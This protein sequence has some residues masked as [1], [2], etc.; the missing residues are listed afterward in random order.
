MNRIA[1]I[2]L[3][4]AVAAS[5][6][7]RADDIDGPPDREVNRAP[8][9][10]VSAGLMAG[11]D[12]YTTQGF[13]GEFGRRIYHTPVF[14]RVMGSAGSTV[15]TGGR[16]T[17]WETR[18]GVEAR[19][20]SPTGMLCGSFGFD[21][22]VRRATADV[23]VPPTENRKQSM[24]PVD[25]PSKDNLD[26]TVFVPR[27]TIDGGNRVRVRGVL[28]FP[29]HMSDNQRISGVAVSLALGVGF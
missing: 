18:A 16:G 4:V 27:L 2:A 29:Q 14:G 15:V 12:H 21:L 25:D 1:R 6:V 22:G 5:P 17:F 8:N 19:T 20:C 3:L 13:V 11:K 24:E 7:A 28:E 9:G 26:S 10:Y 23:Y